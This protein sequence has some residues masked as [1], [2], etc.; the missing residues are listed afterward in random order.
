MTNHGFTAARASQNLA[1]ALRSLLN[2]TGTMKTAF[3][4]YGVSSTTST[5]T[6]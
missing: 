1:Q 3:T 2:P 5:A 4:E 6:S